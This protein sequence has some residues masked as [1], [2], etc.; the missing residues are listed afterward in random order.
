MREKWHWIHTCL[1]PAKKLSLN[2]VGLGFFNPID[3]DL[4]L[5]NHWNACTAMGFMAAYSIHK[6]TVKHES[7][8]LECPHPSSTLSRL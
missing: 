5:N 3:F 1:P 8:Q 6:T 2:E 4:Y 7:P